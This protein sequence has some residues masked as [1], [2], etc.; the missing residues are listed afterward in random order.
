MAGS[1]RSQ[2]DLAERLEFMGI[3]QEAR[4]ALQKLKP[5]IDQAVSPAFGV[6]HENIK[7]NPAARK[8]IADGLDLA[9]VRG[10]QEFHFKTLASG[11][12]SDQYASA[13][14]KVGETHARIGLEPRWHI[15]G[16]A[17]V[18]EQLIHAAIK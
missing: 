1:A 4:A 14:R 8:F 10:R 18:L 9:A 13:V 15:G 5:L 2:Q 11:E 3:D 16:Y 17:L 7:A 6:L 12:F